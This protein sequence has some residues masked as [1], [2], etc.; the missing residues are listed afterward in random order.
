MATPG[1]VVVLA[2]QGCLVRVGVGFVGLVWCVRM[3][4][5]PCQAVVSKD[6]AGMP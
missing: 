5:L 6:G 4:W 2:W 3:T 1:L